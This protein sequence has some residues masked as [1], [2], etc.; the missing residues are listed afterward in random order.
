MEAATTKS[1]HCQMAV[2][3][4]FPGSVNLKGAAAL[5]AEL[6]RFVYLGKIY[7]QE[8][9]AHPLWMHLRKGRIVKE[10]K[11]RSKLKCAAFVDVR[12]IQM[13]GRQAKVL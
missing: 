10:G 2:A 5:T 12:G 13:M 3:E 4:P 7:I 1:F 9:C 6:I 8:P 11:L